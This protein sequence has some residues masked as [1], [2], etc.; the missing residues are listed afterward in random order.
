MTPKV[1]KSRYESV[2]RDAA[3]LRKEISPFLRKMDRI[4]EKADSLLSDLRRD[5]LKPEKWDEKV[6]LALEGVCLGEEITDI[7]D[8]LEY[9]EK[10]GFE[11]NEEKK[12][13]NKKH[14]VHNH[15]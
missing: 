5:G 13:A 14:T 3:K 4:G 10:T 15:V 2:R 9:A 8:A 12:N 7:S 11:I 1:F 6:L